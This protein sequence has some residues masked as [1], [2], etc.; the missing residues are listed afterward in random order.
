L[1]E[2]EDGEIVW[3]MRTL[4]STVFNAG[5]PRRIAFAEIEAVIP[6]LAWLFGDLMIKRLG[7]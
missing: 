5:G 2:H 7:A 4:Q 1:I 6:T 3:P